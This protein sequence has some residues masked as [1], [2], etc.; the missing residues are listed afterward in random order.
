M[1]SLPGLH[2]LSVGPNGSDGPKRQAT[3]DQPAPPVDAN[4]QVL[5]DAG[6]RHLVVAAVAQNTDTESFLSA[7]DALLTREPV[8]RRV[9]EQLWDDAAQRL[10]QTPP[11][12]A[13]SR[14]AFVVAMDA[15]GVVLPAAWRS[16]L[17]RA[18]LDVYEIG[19]FFDRVSRDP[20]ADYFWVR[21]DASRITS[22]ILATFLDATTRRGAAVK[23]V[24]KMRVADAFKSLAAAE[25]D[26]FDRAQLE[27]IADATSKHLFGEF[28]PFVAVVAGHLD[29]ARAAGALPSFEEAAQAAGSAEEWKKFI[30]GMA[31]EPFGIMEG[32]T[33]DWAIGHLGVV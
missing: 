15:R 12:L 6:L 4:M 28:D 5:L 19:R 2:R 10:L 30:H 16:S 13:R 17:E 18:A 29:K 24:L 1:A 21:S 7:A 31:R 33:A 25:R 9:A 11:G 3:G 27:V 32:F 20:Q 8:P 23:L 26:R 22:C 14:D